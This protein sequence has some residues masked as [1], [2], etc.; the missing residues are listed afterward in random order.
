MNHLV[1]EVFDLGTS[2]NPNPT[3]SQYAYLDDNASITINVTSEIFGSGDVWSYD[4]TLNAAANAHIVGSAA[5]IHGSRL[6]DQLDKRR[7]RLWVEGLP[8]FLGYLR[9]DSEANVDANGDISVKF[10]SGQKTFEDM[11]E[12]TKA[13]EVSVGDVEIGIALNRKRV[14]YTPTITKYHITLDGLKAYAIKY[15]V[16]G[17]EGADF[18]LTLSSESAPTPYVQQFPKLVLSHGQ[19]Y[20]NLRGDIE[21]I[22]KTNIQHP[23]DDTPEH[24]FCNVNVCY[25]MKAEDKEGN[26]VTGRGYTVRL[27]RGKETTNGGDSET[28]YNNAPNFYLLYFIDRLFKDMNIQIME[29]QAKSVEDLKRVFMLNYGCH[30]E[31]IES[32][33]LD[34]DKHS[35]PSALI[36]RYGQYYLPIVGNDRVFLNWDCAGKGIKQEDDVLGKVLL[37]DVQIKGL[38]KEIPQIGS[39]EGKVTGYEV[40]DGRGERSK[41]EI[42]IDRG[43]KDYNAY[44]A[45]TAYATGENYPDVEISDIINAMKSMFGVRLLFDDNYKT[46][47]I[48]LLRNV[49]R[50]SE[51]Q[52]ISCDILEENE[53]TES[54]V[55]GFRM[56][57]GKGT[58]DTAFYYKGFNDKLSQKNEIWKDTTDK[59]DY[60]Q[61]RLD[62]EYDKIKNEVSANNKVCYVTPVNGNAYAVKVDEDE[63]VLFPSL[64]PVADFMDAVDGDCSGD[65]DTVEEVQ[66]GASPVIMNDVNGTLASLFS[67]EMKA[68]TGALPAGY[69]YSEDDTETVGLGQKVATYGRIM[70]NR[71]VEMQKHNSILEIATLEALGLD[72]ISADGNIDIYLSEG[73]QIR[74]QDNY[75]IGNGGT[76]FDEADTGLQFGIMRGSGKDAQLL[77]A[78]DTIEDEDPLND[79]WEM[80]P[81]SGAIDS[82]DTCDN[83]GELWDYDGSL[84][85]IIDSNKAEKQMESEWPESNIGLTNRAANTYIAE[86]GVV[87]TFDDE[88]NPFY[89]LLAK[90]T[91]YEILYHGDLKDYVHDVFGDDESSSHPGDDHYFFEKDK[92]GDGTTSHLLI[93]IY[94]AQFYSEGYVQDMGKLL[95]KLQRLAYNENYQ[96]EKIYIDNGVGVT[97]GRF[98]LKLRAEK[99]NPYFD[100]TKEE[101]RYDPAHPEQNTNPRYLHIDNENL[102]GRGLIDQ[103]Y[104]EY[105][106]WKRNAR[107]APKKVRMELAQ[108]LRIDRT[109]KVRVGDVTGYIRKMQYSVSNKTG[110]GDVT[111]E[112]MYI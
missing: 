53:K 96:S 4:F 98:S 32:S 40:G 90:R 55:R 76:P 3:T 75:S 14:V 41:F 12:G 73:F 17:L 92:V 93:A 71:K 47:R 108:L 77:Y 84:V 65:D 29:N 45:Y 61:F 35:T 34:S 97:E 59:H 31:E 18:E 19:V 102:R 27:A 26:E 22:D 105:S 101:T 106:F 21:A 37:R 110:L 69:V 13:T 28:R 100:P 48:V 91:M 36:E 104:K 86:V 88:N 49:F 60:T 109:K 50:D 62:A 52:D 2:D 51:V 82:A 16:E 72:K 46:V 25:Q 74:L 54:S 70:T 24:S 111:M 94:N 87:K 33:D 8:L 38:W 1:L 10:E 43:E 63:A 23:Y 85:E 56:T 68:P 44:S 81:G 95:L 39:I 11:I 112:I 89:L 9:L 107:I 20:K 80:V 66:A 58:E 103:F 64:F 83:Y 42:K 78:P 6:H 30:Y 67:G 5:E 57:Y 15:G 79:Y 7:A 99:P